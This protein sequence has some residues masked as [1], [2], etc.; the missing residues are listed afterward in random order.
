MPF[1]NRKIRNETL[2]QEI[3][4]KHRATRQSR[5][6]QAA[7]SDRIACVIAILQ[8]QPEW[9]YVLNQSAA[10]DAAIY[11]ANYM[12]FTLPY[13]A[14]ETALFDYLSE[15]YAGR[16]IA[17]FAWGLYADQLRSEETP[18]LLVNTV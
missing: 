4:K 9:D 15:H 7:V 14:E 2:N 13:D 17:V 6:N 11:A 1:W 10:R 8:D 16:K 18:L 12:G 3:V 5:L